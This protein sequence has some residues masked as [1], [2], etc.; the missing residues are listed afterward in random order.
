MVGAGVIVGDVSDVCVILISGLELGKIVIVGVFDT[1]A[2][3]VEDDIC[4][5]DD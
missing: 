3:C 1:L 5:R 2:D 4:V